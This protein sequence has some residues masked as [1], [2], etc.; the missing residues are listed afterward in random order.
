VQEAFWVV[1]EEVLAVQCEP[2][3]AVS[4]AV[5]MTLVALVLE[6]YVVVGSC[7]AGRLQGH[8]I[9]RPRPLSWS[10][11]FRAASEQW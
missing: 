5:T 4:V 6:K 8:D 10:S 9:P 7:G 1:H 3:D 11:S 2:S